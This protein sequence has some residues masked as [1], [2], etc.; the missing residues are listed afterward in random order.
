MIDNGTN[1]MY[2]NQAKEA[3][4]NTSPRLADQTRK[5]KR[6]REFRVGTC[7]MILRRSNE[8]SQKDTVKVWQ[9]P[10]MKR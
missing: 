7:M 2:A 8:E 6:N 9:L 1:G 4:S 3:E 10:P 5:Q